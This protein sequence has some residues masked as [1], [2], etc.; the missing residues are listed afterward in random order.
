MPSFCLKLRITSTFLHVSNEGSEDMGGVMRRNEY[1]PQ[2]IHVMFSRESARSGVK[3]PC[4]QLFAIDLM[5]LV[6]INHLMHD[7]NRTDLVEFSAPSSTHGSAV[8]GTRSSYRDALRD[9]VFR[10]SL[11]QRVI[12]TFPVNK[13]LTRQHCVQ[14]RCTGKTPKDQGI[15]HFLLCGEQSSKAAQQGVEHGK[16]GEI[17]R[18]FGAVIGDDLRCLGQERD[19]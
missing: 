15:V 17:S 11:P 2:V 4:Q 5:L 8:L 14:C 10:H 6:T 9:I 13:H 19:G 7:Q 12:P 18:S 3:V 16:G 1:K